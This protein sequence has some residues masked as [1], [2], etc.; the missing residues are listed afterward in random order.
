MSNRFRTAAGSWCDQRDESFAGQPHFLVAV[1]VVVVDTRLDPGPSLA[2]GTIQPDPNAPTLRVTGVAIMGG[3]DVTVRHAG[4]TARD[5]RRRRK[6]ERREKAREIRE[7]AA[8]IRRR[9][10]P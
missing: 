7:G 6:A 4:E 8:D 9:L 5:A 2:D 10:R 3:V 1:E